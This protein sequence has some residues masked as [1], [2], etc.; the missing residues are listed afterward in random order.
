MRAPALPALIVS[1]FTSLMIAGL[2]AGPADARVIKMKFGNWS[3]KSYFNDNGS[4]SHCA[5]STSYKRG[6]LL[7][8]SINGRSGFS[9]GIYDKRWKLTKGKSSKVR[10][11]VDG[12][13]QGT[14]TAKFLSSRQIG[15]FF[16]RD[17]SFFNAL[18]RGKTLRVK[19]RSFSRDYSLKDAAVILQQVR[20]CVTASLEGGTGGIV[21][22]LPGTVDSPQPVSRN[23]ASGNG[24][25]A[26]PNRIVQPYAASILNNIGMSGHKFVKIAAFSKRGYNASWRY[27][28]GYLGAISAYRN[29][30]SDFVTAET[31]GIIAR[32]RGSC[33]GQFASGHRQ[34]ESNLT[35]SGS[36]VFTACR[37]STDRNDY[38]IHYTV[39]R[40]PSGTGVIIATVVLF[41][42]G[43]AGKSNKL[44]ASIDKSIYESPVFRELGG[45]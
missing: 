30:R 45:G 19:G 21:A 9:A 44:G 17:R 5:V 20:K 4:F 32:D 25:N 18:S 11:F 43:G 35:W 2:T 39:G 22:A 3:G 16:G 14:Y 28:E 37:G 12:T 36:R 8:F 7:V 33:T 1:V 6:D 24:A 42:N 38:V 40:L 34:D 27:R 31:A 15:V 41:K 29:A 26:L 23:Q 13:S 10:L